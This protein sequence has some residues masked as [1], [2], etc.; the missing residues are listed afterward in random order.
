[1]IGCAHRCLPWA[2]Y[3]GCT[4]IARLSREWRI[5]R[6]EATSLMRQAVDLGEVFP[7]PGKR[8]AAAQESLEE[9]VTWPRGLRLSV[10][11]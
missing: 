11:D 7:L 10:H 9:A 1:M 2:V 8:F 6:K 3:L 5:T 4:T